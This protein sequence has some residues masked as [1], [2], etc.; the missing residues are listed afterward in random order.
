MGTD[1]IGSNILIDLSLLDPRYS[2]FRQSIPEFLLLSLK[3]R[4]NTEERDELFIN[5][6]GSYPAVPNVVNFPKS[7]DSYLIDTLGI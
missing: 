4:I 7:N 6:K 1:S 5:V 2:I 3:S